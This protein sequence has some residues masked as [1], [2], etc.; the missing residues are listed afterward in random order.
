MARVPFEF[1][2]DAISSLE[3]WTRPMFGCLAVYVGARIVLI[4]R[5]KADKSPEKTRDNGV[6][7]ATT[8]EHHE[9]LHREFP[10]MRSIGVLGKEVT[11]WQVLPSD[12][13]DFEEAA[14][15]ACDLILARDARIGKIPKA[16]AKPVGNRLRRVNRNP[17]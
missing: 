17:G 8:K 7:V 2:L 9:S 4:L 13:A 11:G 1:V 6:W 5:D 10:S 12:A 15:R 14:L 16:K 3:P